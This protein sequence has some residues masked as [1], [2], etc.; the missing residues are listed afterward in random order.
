MSKGEVRRLPTIIMKTWFLRYM[1][2]PASDR[3]LLVCAAFAIIKA[4]LTVTFVPL[5]QIL[6][7]LALQ[8]AALSP[9]VD[10]ARIGWAVETVS[11]IVPTG[12][13]CL[14]RAMA[15][16]TILARYGF[17]GEIRL[18]IRKNSSDV[19][20]G[21]AWL[22]CGDQIITGESEHQSYMMMPLGEG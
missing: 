16:R 13:N 15:A 4:R 8:T 7:P 21:H 11:R 12:K 19:L 1:K 3:W 10:A 5:R 6:K 20:N 9:S 22:E 14:V 2:L 17:R 18:G